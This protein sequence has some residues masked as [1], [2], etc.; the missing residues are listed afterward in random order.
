LDEAQ[1]ARQALDG[2][3]WPSTNP[4]TLSVR[5]A[6]QE[7]VSYPF[8]FKSK[9][10]SFVFLFSSNTVKFMMH[11]R[12]IYLLVQSNVFIYFFQYY[13]ICLLDSNDRIVEESINQIELKNH[14]DELKL[15][16]EK[17]SG[18]LITDEEVDENEESGLK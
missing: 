17:Q 8:F 18:F 4:K 10:L 14:S 12:I 7:E 3:Q 13:F 6:R 15:Q 1:N 9:I 2:C 16:K 11:H 5:Y